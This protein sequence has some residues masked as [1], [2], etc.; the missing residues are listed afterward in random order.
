MRLSFPSS[1][2]LHNAHLAIEHADEVAE[3][4]NVLGALYELGVRSIGLT[5]T[6]SSAAA[7]GCFEAREGAGL[8][9]FG[10]RVGKPIGHSASLAIWPKMSSSLFRVSS[11][12]SL[13]CTAV[14]PACM[15]VRP[16]PKS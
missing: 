12:I 9:R 10:P 15:G 2:P 16:S 11:R 6:T 3:S 13:V 1:S 8:T 7:D 5:H 4:L 14:I